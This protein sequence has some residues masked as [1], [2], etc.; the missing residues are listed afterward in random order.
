[1]ERGK[2]KEGGFFRVFCGIRIQMVFSAGQDDDFGNQGLDD[3]L[4]LQRMR[5]CHQSTGLNF[6]KFAMAIPILKV[7]V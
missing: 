2:N 1:V 5:Y 7:N 4:N 3:A 6:R